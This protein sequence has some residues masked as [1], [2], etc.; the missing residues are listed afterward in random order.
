MVKLGKY[1][2][3][4]VAVKSI[5][6]ENFKKNAEKEVALLAN[7]RHPNIITVLVQSEMQQ[8]IHIAMEYFEGFTLDDLIF[9]K[10]TRLQNPLDLEA[11]K[12]IV[13]Q[14]TKAITYCHLQKPSPI[15]HR[16]IKP[17]NIM[18]QPGSVSCLTKVC[19]YGL[20]KCKD[21]RKALQ[22]TVKQG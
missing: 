19:D 9:D 14:I 5:A 1:L 22:S 11:K 18:V 20:G 6:K 3:T 2:G 10:G 15:I 17:D 21:L 8:H 13:K 7:L 16:N 4:A 12:K